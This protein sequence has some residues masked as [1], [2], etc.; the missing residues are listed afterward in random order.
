MSQ[1]HH[2]IPTFH[3]SFLDESPMTFSRMLG[4]GYAGVFLFERGRHRLLRVRQHDRGTVTARCKAGYWQ[5]AE[6]QALNIALCRHD[7]YGMTC[8]VSSWRAP[9]DCAAL[10]PSLASLSGVAVSP[11]CGVG[12]SGM[13]GQ[14]DSPAAGNRYQSC[15]DGRT[16]T[17]AGFLDGRVALWAR[18]TCGATKQRMVTVSEFVRSIHRQW[19]TGRVDPA[20]FALPVPG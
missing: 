18:Q 4:Y 16:R 11:I 1:H 14:E 20:R 19:V 2:S 15:I 13:T 12:A 6:A 17:G 3:A 5:A 9:Q 8:T 7:L 10:R